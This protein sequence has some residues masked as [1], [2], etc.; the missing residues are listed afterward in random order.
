MSDLLP[1]AVLKKLWP[2]GN[3]HVPG[4]IEGIAASAPVV[5]QR[6]GV[7]SQLVVA[8]MMAQFSEECGAGLEMVENLNYSAEGLLRT[9][10]SH[11]TGTMAYRYA[12]NPR[13][14]ADVAY[15]GRMGNAKPPSDDGWNYRGKGLSQLTGKENYAKLAIITGLDVMNVPDLLIQPA[16]AF[17]GAVA[18]FVRICGCLPYAER[19][20]AH[21][22]T[23][24]L[25]GGL[26][27]YAERLRWL[28]L[29]KP[30]LAA[31]AHH[32]IVS[33]APAAAMAAEMSAGQFSNKAEEA[34]LRPTAAT[35]TAAVPG[36]R[37]SS[38]KPPP[39]SDLDTLKDK[40]N[41]IEKFLEG[42]V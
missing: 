35:A 16:T 14:I 10:P 38:T 34:P 20:D 9:W 37:P 2:H 29:W 17:E 15:G 30:A 25:N 39:P 31:E 32:T 5:F 7:K 42:Y 40:L 33:A 28:R 12:H 18:D 11:F 13:M 27:G 19:D 3:Q 36:S 24:H 22:V 41:R 6:H 8:H 21:G 4:L 1:L 26:N 23:V